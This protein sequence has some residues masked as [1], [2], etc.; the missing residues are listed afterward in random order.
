MVVPGTTP[1]NA[2]A[3]CDVRCCRA[4]RGGAGIVIM[5]AVRDPFPHVSVHVKKPECVWFKGTDW[6]GLL[7]VPLA[8]AAPAIRTVL[9]YL[10]SPP[11]LRLVAGA[12]RNF[13]LGLGE[14]QVVLT[15]L[16]P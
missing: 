2:Q 1:K 13:P 11:I 3:A 12:C 6:G 5:V 4:V 16:P 15:R 14:Q 9:A 8:T 7:I 10:V